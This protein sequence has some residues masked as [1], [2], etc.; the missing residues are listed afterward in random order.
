MVAPPVSCLG[1]A[2]TTP[3]RTLVLGLRETPNLLNRTR[4]PNSR[5]I[6]IWLSLHAVNRGST[7]R[8]CE[9]MRERRR[10]L[11]PAAAFSRPPLHAG[12][13]THCRQ[14]DR[15]GAGCSL[16]CAN[17]GCMPPSPSRG[18]SARPAAGGKSSI[19][20]RRLPAR[21]QYLNRPPTY[22]TSL[23]P[24]GQECGDP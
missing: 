24:F 1:S 16:F 23:L 8:P 7:P 12:G 21:A 14:P 15:R 22:R 5:S 19:S 9:S 6:V 3:L 4:S 17:P 11:N 2:T 13:P 20:G 10:C 18:I